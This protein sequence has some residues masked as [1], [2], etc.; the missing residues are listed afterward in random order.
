MTRGAYSE[1]TD[2]ELEIQREKPVQYVPFS[3][4]WTALM[5][6]KSFVM[7]WLTACFL[8]SIFSLPL[9]LLEHH[10]LPTPSGGIIYIELGAALI[11]S[12]ATIACW[13]RAWIWKLIA[14]LATI[15]IIITQVILLGIIALHIGGLAGVQ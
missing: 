2:S 1:K 9:F 4:F 15:F 10:G 11:L 12:L 5:N 6:D 3:R 8:P 14:G 7:I 13:K